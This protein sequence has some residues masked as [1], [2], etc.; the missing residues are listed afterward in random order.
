[1]GEPRQVTLNDALWWRTRAKIIARRDNLIQIDNWRQEFSKRSKLSASRA[2][3]ISACFIGS[4]KPLEISSIVSRNSFV[5]LPN[6]SASSPPV[7][8]N[9]WYISWAIKEVREFWN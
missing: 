7:A 1:M 3:I 5:T 8:A 9:L 4:S 6:S 2:G